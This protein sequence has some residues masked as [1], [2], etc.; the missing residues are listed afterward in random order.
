MP[1]LGRRRG[2][3]DVLRCRYETVGQLGRLQQ[4][5]GCH[6]ISHQHGETHA[7]IGTGV[8]VYLDE[9]HTARRAGGWWLV[10]ALVL[11]TDPFREVGEKGEEGGRC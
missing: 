3:G 2:H 1:T 7:G 11:D 8:I 9:N 4:L 6:Q 10:L 5:Q